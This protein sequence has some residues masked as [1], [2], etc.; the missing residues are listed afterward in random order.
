MFYS[1]P[2]DP[3][4]ARVRISCRAFKHMIMS[5]F[6]SWDVSIR[7]VGD[8]SEIANFRLSTSPQLLSDILSFKRML[9]RDDDE[10]DTVV[11]A[12]KLSIIG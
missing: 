2:N 5:Q 9:L 1:S 11:L 3:M 7:I 8:A 6:G 10:V 4:A 12:S